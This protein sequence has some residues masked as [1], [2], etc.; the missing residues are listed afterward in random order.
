MRKAETRFVGRR[1]AK[2]V[3]SRTDDRIPGDEGLLT[4]KFEIHQT[5]VSVL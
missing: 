2:R 4:Q 1:L 5:M 3:E